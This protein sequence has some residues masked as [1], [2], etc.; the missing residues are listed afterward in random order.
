MIMKFENDVEIDIM[1]C[2]ISLRENQSQHFPYEMEITVSYSFGLEYFREWFDEISHL[3]NSKNFT[4]VHLNQV[5]N[6]N[7]VLDRIYTPYSLGSVGE[8]NVR[9]FMRYCD[10][11]SNDKLSQYRSNLLKKY[12]LK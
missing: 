11:Y 7:G 12:E 2:A 8:N 6:F 1:R 10:I 3:D 9:L 5:T 4:I